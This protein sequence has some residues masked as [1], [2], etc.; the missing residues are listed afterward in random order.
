MGH[1]PRMTR[2]QVDIA[3]LR[4][5]ARQLGAS[6][7]DLA[8]AHNRAD[9]VVDLD[10]PRLHDGAATQASTML[11]EALAACFR[12]GESDRRLASALDSAADNAEQLEA[13]LVACLMPA[14]GSRLD[15]SA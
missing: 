12:L 14:H 1:D 8:V 9:Q 3:G 7:D 4:T 13:I 2:V 11:Q 10:V 5:A 6:A 15:A